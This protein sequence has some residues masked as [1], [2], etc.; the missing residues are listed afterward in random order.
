MTRT[1]TI[2]P[3]DGIIRKLWLDE[4]LFRAVIGKRGAGLVWDAE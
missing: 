1:M 3:W 4:I 2:D